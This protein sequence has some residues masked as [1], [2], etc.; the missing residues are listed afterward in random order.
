M[1]GKELASNEYLQIGKIALKKISLPS[2]LLDNVEI[3]S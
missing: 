2:N 1:F 3:I